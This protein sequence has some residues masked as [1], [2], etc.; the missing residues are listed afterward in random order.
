VDVNVHVVGGDKITP[1]EGAEVGVVCTCIE[2]NTSLGKASLI[3]DKDGHTSVN[4]PLVQY[5]TYK[6][7]VTA[8][9]DGFTT[10]K[11]ETSFILEPRL[12]VSVTVDQQYS[13]CVEYYEGTV[14]DVLNAPVEGATIDFWVKSP[15]GK[16]TGPYRTTSSTGGVWKKYID[17][18][19]DA[20]R[21]KYIVQYQ[22]SKEGYKPSTQYE[23]WFHTE[24]K[25]P[26]LE[27]IM[28]ALTGLG[29]AVRC[30]VNVLITDSN[31]R[32][33]GCFSNGTLV[34]DIPESYF[35][36]NETSDGRYWLF[37]L[38]DGTYSITITGTAD[39]T[40]NLRLALDQN[41]IAEYGEQPIVENSNATMNLDPDNPAPPLMLSNG[42]VV[43]PSVDGRTYTPSSY[44]ETWTV[45]S[46]TELSVET[47]EDSS[48]GLTGLAGVTVVIIILLAVTLAWRK[49]KKTSTPSDHRESTLP[50]EV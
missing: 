39:G 29:I 27:E 18:E 2:D 41:T 12:K 10:G 23:T 32:C 20:E 13:D 26:T 15:S 25:L 3:T 31:G 11:A 30:P 40:F 4:V 14:K 42:E 44:T 19:D 17:M 28:R 1:I 46:T 38:P 49:R 16:L 35:N 6:V 47:V 34:H 33:D 9:K 37:G 50:E 36:M 22:A 5:G 8:S 7:E 45:S 21:G 24:G 48:G 43:E